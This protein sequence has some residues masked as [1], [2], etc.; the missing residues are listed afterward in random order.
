MAMWAAPRGPAGTNC[1]AWQ[2]TFQTLDRW[3]VVTGQ[4]PGYIPSTHVGYYESGNVA[5]VHPGLLRLTLTQEAGPVDG[6]TGINS[7]GALI[8]SNQVCGYGTYSWTMKMSSD[9]LCPDLSCTGS[10]Y[11]GSVSAGFLYVNNSQTEIDFEFQGQDAAAIYLVNWLNPRPSSD[12]TGRNETLTRQ[13]F[14]PI[15]DQHTYSF[16]WT[17]GKIAYYI[18]GKFVV[19]HTTNV[20][21]APAYFMINHWGTDSLNWGGMATTGVTRYMYVTQASYT[22]PAK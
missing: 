12:P 3:T 8:R 9:A 18:D 7:F 19:N 21:S 15:N 13:P 10:A 1:A 22:P 6:T 11:S 20:P 14:T 17:K 5:L 4:A 2:D 16:V